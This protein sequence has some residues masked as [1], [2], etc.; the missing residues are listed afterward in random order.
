MHLFTCIYM[1]EEVVNL[2]AL[3]LFPFDSGRLFSITFCNLC[4]NVLMEVVK[5]EH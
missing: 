5:A 1:H 4:N 3:D 2:L